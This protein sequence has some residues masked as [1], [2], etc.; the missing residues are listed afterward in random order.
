MGGNKTA[1][2]LRQDR[3]RLHHAAALVE[4]RFDLRLLAQ[5]LDLFQVVPGAEALAGSREDHDPDEVARLLDM[6]RQLLPSEPSSGQAFPGRLY[7]PE[8]VRAFVKAD[9]VDTETARRVAGWQHP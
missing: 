7:S 5:R 2:R 4:E 3:D 6:A 9:E 1:D 8:E